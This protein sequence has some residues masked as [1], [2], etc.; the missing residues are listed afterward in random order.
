MSVCLFVCL[1]VYL[2]V[3]LTFH[4]SSWYPS[5]ALCNIPQGVCDMVVRCSVF[6]PP[7]P[8]EGVFNKNEEFRNFL[9]P[10][11]KDVMNIHCIAIE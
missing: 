11:C 8:K 9:L 5:I 1:F 7:I 2:S 10:K 3:R 4:S 6:G